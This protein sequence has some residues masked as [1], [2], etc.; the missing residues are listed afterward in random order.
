MLAVFVQNQWASKGASKH[1]SV[2]GNQCIS[3]EPDDSVMDAEKIIWLSL[4]F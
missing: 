4:T 1:V 2:E 3:I